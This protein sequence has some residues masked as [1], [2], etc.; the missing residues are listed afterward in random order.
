VATDKTNPRFQ[1]VLD[2]AARLLASN[3]AHY[4]FEQGANETFLAKSVDVAVK[5]VDMVKEIVRDR[6]RSKQ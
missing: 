1:A 5:L 4:G 6:P 2:V 3:S